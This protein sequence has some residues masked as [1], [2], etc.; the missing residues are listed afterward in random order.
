M[1]RLYDEVQEDPRPIVDTELEMEADKSGMI[2]T[3]KSTKGN[4]VLPGYGTTEF[5]ISSFE[6]KKSALTSMPVILG[7]GIGAAGVLGYMFRE[8]LKTGFNTVTTYALL[9]REASRAEK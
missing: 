5:G 4:Q 2:H 7:A 3:R 8:G 6:P 1:P 9:L